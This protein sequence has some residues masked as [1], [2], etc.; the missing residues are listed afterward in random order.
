MTKKQKPVL[1]CSAED[2]I[3]LTGVKPTHYGYTIDKDI[4]E[5][6]KKYKKQS[7]EQKEKLDKIL[8]N[9]IETA[10]GM[11]DEYINTSF[12]P[13]EIPKTVKLVCSLIVSNI[14]AYTSVRRDVPVRKK[15][16]WNQDIVK[17]EIFPDELKEMLDNYVVE[18]TIE[19]DSISIFA[20]TGD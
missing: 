17:V 15:D 1:Y 11:I 2:V 14:I 5:D 18:E 9:Y 6:K 20:I 4:I 7:N 3:K 12:K 16:D 10:T 8:N 19:K 13:K